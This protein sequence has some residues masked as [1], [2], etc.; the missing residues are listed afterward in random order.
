MTAINKENTN[1]PGLKDMENDPEEKRPKF[2]GT[3]YLV[4]GIGC[5]AFSL[6]SIVYN[7]KSIVPLYGTQMT[8]ALLGV[9]SIF[10]IIF[11]Y[12]IIKKDY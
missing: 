10:M 1:K 3:F 9:L 11:G 7:F 12:R 4:L 2:W 8:G 6:Y 5:L